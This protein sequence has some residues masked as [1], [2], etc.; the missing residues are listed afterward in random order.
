MMAAAGVVCVGAAEQPAEEIRVKNT[1]IQN[2]RNGIIAY[3]L[4]LVTPGKGALFH[5]SAL[6]QKRPDN[7][8]RFS[9]CT[10]QRFLIAT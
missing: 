10:D 6:Q 9:M 2:A 5:N 4:T 1:T 3:L 7:S 8:G